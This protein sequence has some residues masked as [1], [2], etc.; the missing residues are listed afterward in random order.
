MRSEFLRC[1]T[2]AKFRS[3][4]SHHSSFQAASGEEPEDPRA[5]RKIISFSFTGGQIALYQQGERKPKRGWLQGRFTVRLLPYLWE[6]L[7]GTPPLG[8]EDGGV[9]V[10]MDYREPRNQPPRPTKRG[11][12]ILTTHSMSRSP[13][14]SSGVRVTSLRYFARWDGTPRNSYEDGRSRRS[15]LGRR[16]RTP[17]PCEAIL[18]KARPLLDAEMLLTEIVDKLEIDRSM[19]T[20]VYN[21]YRAEK[22]LPPLDGRS[23]RKLLPRKSRPP[24]NPEPGTGFFPAP[25]RVASSVFRS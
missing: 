6:D 15:R 16:Q 23:R 7:T 22:G 21:L 18:A 10:I 14:C 19:M 24:Q 1:R 13:R 17:L 2:C 11:N 20:K 3:N 8:M 12:F 4:S 5:V 9:E 25:I